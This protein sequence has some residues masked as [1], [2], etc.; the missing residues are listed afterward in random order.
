MLDTKNAILAK[1][2][3]LPFHG[4]KPKYPCFYGQVSSLVAGLCGM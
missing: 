1:P 3:S 4:D 2:L